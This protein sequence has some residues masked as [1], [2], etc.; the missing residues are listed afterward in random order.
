MRVP[1]AGA[2][3]GNQLPRYPPPPQVV[4]GW[5]GQVSGG[6][7]VRLPAAGTGSD[8]RSLPPLASFGGIREEEGRERERGRERK[9]PMIDHKTWN[10]YCLD[11]K[12][13]GFLLVFKN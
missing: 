2:T 4:A 13:G 10:N 3:D 5:G 9:S 7:G 8:G 1:Y 11:Q 6:G 12:V